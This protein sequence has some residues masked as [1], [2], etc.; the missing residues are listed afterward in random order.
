[1][2][3]GNVRG[4]L[5][6]GKIFCRNLQRYDVIVHKERGKTIPHAWQ[7]M[8]KVT[9]SNLSKQVHE[10]HHQGKGF[11]KQAGFHGCFGCKGCKLGRRR[12][13]RFLLISR[14]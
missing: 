8:S 7:H 14:L 4:R 3:L 1:M 5:G 12:G 13:L 9:I 2:S 6:K 10:L 11:L